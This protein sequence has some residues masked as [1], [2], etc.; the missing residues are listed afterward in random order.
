MLPVVANLTGDDMIAIA[1]YVTSRAAPA[2]RS[3]P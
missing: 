1:A 2:P 3:P